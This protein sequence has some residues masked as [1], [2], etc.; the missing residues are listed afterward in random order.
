MAYYYMR[1][2]MYICISVHEKQ[3]IHKHT[4]IQMYTNLGAHTH[5]QNPPSK[6][7]K[8]NHLNQS[9]FENVSLCLMNT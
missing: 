4:N 9:F 5:K 7:K 2:Y 1:R 3:P 6:T 8:K